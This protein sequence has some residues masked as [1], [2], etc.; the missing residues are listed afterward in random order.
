MGKRI[1]RTDDL[2]EWF[3]SSK[4]DDATRLDA[5]GWHEQLNIRRL[6]HEMLEESEG[7]DD[8]EGLLDFYG[9][10]PADFLSAVRASPIFTYRG[11]KFERCVEESMG[12]DHPIRYQSAYPPGIFGIT[13]IDILTIILEWEPKLREE[14]LDWLQSDNALSPS[15]TRKYPPRPTRNWVFKPLTSRYIT[16]IQINPNFPDKVLQKSLSLF[17]SRQREVEGS[18]SP[19]KDK[20]SNTFMEWCD[21]GLLQYLDLKIWSFQEKTNITNKAL[22]QGIF[23]NNYEKG[24]E[25]IRTTTKKHAAMILSP[26]TN[27]AISMAVLLADARLEHFLVSQELK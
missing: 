5:R 2:P 11:S 23:P 13:P 15:Q 24:E 4:Y 7:D 10:E 27:S 20:R 26:R 19:L 12:S 22:A 3:E 25:N 16:P 18:E 8:E 17:I 21:C 9:C 1:T 6:C 14:F